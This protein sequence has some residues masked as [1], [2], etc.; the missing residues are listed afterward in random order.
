VTHNVEHTFSLSV[1][2]PCLVRLSPDEHERYIWV[3]WRDAVA[4]CISPTNREAL[5]LLPSIAGVR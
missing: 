3:G 2:A 4:R 5:K 1:P